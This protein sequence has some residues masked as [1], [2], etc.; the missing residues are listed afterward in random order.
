MTAVFLGGQAAKS[1]GFGPGDVLVLGGNA[2]D[3]RLSDP[4]PQL[5]WMGMFRRL[6]A[7]SLLQ[8]VMQHDRT[9][10]VLTLSPTPARVR[11]VRDLPADLVAM[12][13]SCRAPVRADI[14]EDSFVSLRGGPPV[15]FL[16]DRGGCALGGGRAVSAH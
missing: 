4:D 6:L 15:A 12:T 11:Q 5:Y 7:R 14:G 16:R 1:W 13:A 10:E 3:D 9:P 2:D 8:A